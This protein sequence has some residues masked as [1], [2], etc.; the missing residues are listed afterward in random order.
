MLTR[1]T[2]VETAVHD[3]NCWLW[4]VWTLSVPCTVKRCTQYQPC[5][6]VVNL[7]HL[8]CFMV[9]YHLFGVFLRSFCACSKY[10]K[11]SLISSFQ[12]ICSFRTKR[13]STDCSSSEQNHAQCWCHVER[14]SRRPPTQWHP[15]LHSNLPFSHAWRSNASQVNYNSNTFCNPH[16]SYQEHKLQHHC[17]GFKPRW[18]W[19]P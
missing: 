7:H 1:P 16:K 19:T 9:W 12:L 15:E 3:C 6:I 14:G 5:F 11:I 13:T 8:C 2:Q 10:L 17:D 18:Q 4:S